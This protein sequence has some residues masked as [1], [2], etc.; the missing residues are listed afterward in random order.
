MHAEAK[1]RSLLPFGRR[2]IQ[3]LKAVIEPGYV[4]FGEV[5]KGDERKQIVRIRFEGGQG[6]VSGRVASGPAWLEVNPP[7]FHRR[8][9]SLT[10]TAL[11]DR[12]WQKGDYE[13]VVRLET[14]AGEVKIPVA[15]RVLKARPRFSQVALWFVPVLF[16]VVLP[17]LTVAWSVQYS[18]ARY[19][20]PA[21]A[22]GSALLAVMLLL[23]AK[24][25]DLGFGEKL[26]CGVLLAVMAMVLGV[27]MGVATRTGRPD[28]MGSLPS[29]GVPMGLV[30]AFQIASRKRWQI[31]A[32]VIVVLSLL[33]AGT[34]AGSLANVR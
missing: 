28:I 9:P 3:P 15:I 27:S 8:T 2:E 7:V 19:L 6:K 26:S 31:W 18:S 23:V 32:G 11:S 21:A 30:L 34:F 33:A 17:A 10:V 14:D 13:D 25:A 24:E 4:H 12:V 29:T 5:R 1:R 22:L 20:V 16:S